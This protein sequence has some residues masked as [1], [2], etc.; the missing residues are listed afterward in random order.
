MTVHVS[1]RGVI[2]ELRLTGASVVVA[3]I[4]KSN[5]EAFRILWVRRQEGVRGIP[6]PFDR[7]PCQANKLL[8]TATA[9][10]AVV[11]ARYGS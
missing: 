5:S 7:F 3:K 8:A 6:L 11:T 9:N 10:P 4:M 1:L 2:K